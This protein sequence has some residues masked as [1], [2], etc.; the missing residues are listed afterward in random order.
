MLVRPLIA[1]LFAA[2]ALAGT[3]CNGLTRPEPITIAP[4]PKL[5]PEPTP[6]PAPAAPKVAAAQPAAHGAAPSG[7]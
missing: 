3:G 2:A 7:G 4:E 6:A 1:V 5:A